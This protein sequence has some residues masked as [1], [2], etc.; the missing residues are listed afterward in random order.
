MMMGRGVAAAAAAAMLKLVMVGGAKVGM[1]QRSG[2]L[3]LLLWM[4]LQPVMR[5]VAW[6]HVILLLL[7]LR[8]KRL[9]SLL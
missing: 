4:G 6:R 5:G 8:G 7:L 9:G 3:L 2:L 1:R